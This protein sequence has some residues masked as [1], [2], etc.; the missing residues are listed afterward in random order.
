M[1]NHVVQL[2]VSSTA[3]FTA[4]CSA[5]AA[6]VDVKIKEYKLP[7]LISIGSG[8]SLNGLKDFLG[9]PDI[10]SPIIYAILFLLFFYVWKLSFKRSL[11]A[12]LLAWLFDLLF[13]QFFQMNLMELLLQKSGIAAD[14]FI[15]MMVTLFI[16]LNCLVAAGFFYRSRPV[17]FSEALFSLDKE[18]VE[19]NKRFN[20]PFYF[21]LFLLFLLGIFLHYLFL[22]RNT[23]PTDFRFFLTLSLLFFSFVWLCLLKSAMQQKIEQRE[24]AL[25]QRYQQELLHFLGVIRSQ[26]HDFN[27]HLNSVYGLLQHNQFGEAKSYIT[28]LVQQTQPVNELLLLQQ[29]AVSALLNTEMEEASRKAIQIHLQIYDDLREMPC[30]VHAMNK[31]LGNLIRNAVEEVDAQVPLEEKAN[32]VVKVEISREYNQIVIRV[33][34]PADFQEEEKLSAIFKAGY[35]TKSAHEG[36]GLFSVSQIV[37]RCHGVLFPEMKDGEITMHVRLPYHS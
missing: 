17:Y 7:L 37:E 10:F 5:G 15:E 31:I 18:T 29:P 13:I 8:A 28:E 1:Q 26:R 23:L 14:P 22:S 36:V 34:N 20:R 27:F 32:R 24:L 11:A 19:E 9:V 4:V 12:A 16:S 2:L 6:A 3:F 25:E 30:S 33:T 35:S 21:N